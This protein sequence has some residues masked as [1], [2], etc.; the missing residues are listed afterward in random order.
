[1][2][3]KN[4]SIIIVPPDSSRVVNKEISQRLLILCSLIISCFIVAS[5]YSAIGF[6]RSSVDRQ[7]MSGLL[8]ENGVLSAKIGNLESTVSLL[9]SEMSRIIRTD[10]DIRLVFDLPDLDSDMREVGVGGQIIDAPPVS[11]ELSE[12]TWLVEEDIE[13]I[14]RQ[15]DLENASFE[16]LLNMVRDKRLILDHTPTISPCD[17][18]M[19]RGF[20]MHNDPFTGSYQPHNGV[21]I[22]APKGTPVYATAAGTVVGTSY[23]TGLGNTIVINHEN[24]FV[25]YYGHLSKIMVAAGRKVER[26]E[27]VGL[28]GSTGYSTGPHVHYE[29]R[30]HNRAVDPSKYIIKTILALR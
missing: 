6:I 23:Q 29:V 25:T 20:G 26:G 9:K 4:F 15:L 13:K 14:R 2:L 12:R 11:S 18:F 27:V 19:T 1:M 8:E 22:A 16:Q 21:D 5:I 17:G 28:V 7:R 24:G 3:R 10:E 30:D